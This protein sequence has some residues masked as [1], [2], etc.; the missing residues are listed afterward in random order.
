MP[1]PDA[2]DLNELERALAGLLPSAAGLDRDRLMFQAGRTARGPGR[3]RWPAATGA[4]TAVAAGLGLM[5]LLRADPEPVIVVHNAPVIQSAVP[6]ANQSAPADAPA[7]PRAAD[8]VQ[9]A[10]SVWRLQETALRHGPDALPE[11][12]PSGAPAP[13]TAAAAEVLTAGA[14]RFR[15]TLDSS[16]LNAGGD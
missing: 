9:A 14:G 5:L 11:P 12:G 10:Q 3:W 6:A 15:S 8:N 7:P 1:E 13:A 2:K 16:L 4:M